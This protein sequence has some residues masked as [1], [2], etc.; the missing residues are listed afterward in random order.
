[1]DTITIKAQGTTLKPT[2]YLTNEGDIPVY[3]SVSLIADGKKVYSKPVLLTPGQNIINLEWNIPKTDTMTSY[4]IQTQLDVYDKSYITGMATLDTF[5]R[6]KVVPMSDQHDIVPAIN[7][8]VNTIARPA[9]IYSSNEGA[10]VF[11]VTAPDGTCVI[12]AG[13]LVEESTLKHRGGIDSVLV[14]GH[15]YRVR[16]SGDDS[17][18]ERFSIT[19][20]DS[21]LG[22][23]NVQIVDTSEFVASAAGD[24]PIKV[25]YRAEESPLITVGME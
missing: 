8:L 15:I 17:P 14:D 20:L 2:A 23:W 10:G 19:S 16:Y 11:K 9:M 4:K 3:S 24:V 5:A 25:Q 1:M 12:G 22:Q 7:E 13:C 21:V 18:L 6:T